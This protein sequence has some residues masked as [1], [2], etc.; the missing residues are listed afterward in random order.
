MQS[1]NRIFD[2]FAKV[3]NGAAG[4]NIWSGGGVA[5][6]QRSARLYR[7]V[8][9]KGLASSVSGSVPAESFRPAS[10]A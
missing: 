7:A 3:L 6:P 5:R 4:L 2:D 8:V 9:D 1:D 10:G